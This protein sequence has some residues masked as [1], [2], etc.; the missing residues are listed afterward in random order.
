VHA[1]VV[2]MFAH[3]AATEGSTHP[4]SCLL[5]PPLHSAPAVFF[6]ASIAAVRAL[7]R[8]SGARARVYALAVL[9]LHPAAL[10]IDHGHFQYNSISLGLTLAAVAAIL[11]GRQLLGAAM[12]SLSLNHKQVRAA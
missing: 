3:A 7:Y 4:G 10:I 12:F 1:K 11:S 2:G 9:L 8:G 5:L 6:P